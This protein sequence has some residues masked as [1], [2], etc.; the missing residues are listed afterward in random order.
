MAREYLFMLMLRFSAKKPSFFLKIRFLFVL[1]TFFL[2][3]PLFIT[4]VLP[5]AEGGGYL[6]E[7][8]NLPGCRS[9]R[10]TIQEAIENGRDAVRCW[11][12][13]V[14]AHGD[15]IPAPYSKAKH[16]GASLNALVI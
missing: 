2:Y 8:P 15:E 10:E 9:D 12:E 4:S 16:E 5:E 14:R 3:E 6:I 1:C 11:I 7:Y 13:T